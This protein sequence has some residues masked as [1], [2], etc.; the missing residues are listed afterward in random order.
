MIK[1]L[2]IVC[3]LMLHSST[4][5]TTLKVN[6]ALVKFTIKNAG[7]T[8]EG[9]LSGFEGDIQ[10]D[11][12]AIA[13]ST[14]KGSVQVS[15]IKTGFTS[16]D[17]HL[18]KEE[19]F[20]QAKFPKIELVSSFFGKAEQGFRGYFKLTL[21]GV[22][23]DVVIPFTFTEEGGIINMKGSFTLNRL[24]YGIGK[25]SMILDDEVKVNLQFSLQKI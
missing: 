24:D 5:F 16:R 22:T 14:I 20:N 2:A 3:V 23:K 21:K 15:T 11:P 13:R 7:L 12:Q 10:F 25:S 8:V 17:K 6:Q 1:A 9:S 4:T 18:Q 19:Y